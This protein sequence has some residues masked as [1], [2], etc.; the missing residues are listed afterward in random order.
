MDSDYDIVAFR[1]GDHPVL[2]ETGHWRGAQLDIFVYPTVRLAN[3]DETLLH[4]R[5]GRVISE[6]GVLGSEFLAELERI[7]RQPPTPLSKDVIDAKR[8]W[9]HKMVQ[10]AAHGDIEGNFRRVW[11]LT[12]LLEDYYL[13]RGRRYPGPKEAFRDLAK[14]DVQALRAFRVAL[15]PSSAL[16]DISAA[17]AH[18]H[19]GLPNIP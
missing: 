16:S 18:V 4:I 1:D 7:Y 5:G 12:Q 10:R 2:R 3:V 19:G 8:N 15:E 9:A 14:S 11:L 17:A 6:R 13:V